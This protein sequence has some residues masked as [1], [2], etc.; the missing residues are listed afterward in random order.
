M[1]KRGKGT[2]FDANKGVKGVEDEGVVDH[3]IVVELSQEANIG[4]QSLIKDII[5]SKNKNISKK[6]YN[7][8]K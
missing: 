7:N 2:V 8:R 3:R 4:D 5:R 6:L 1:V